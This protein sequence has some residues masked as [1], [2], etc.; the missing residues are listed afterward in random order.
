VKIPTLNC[1]NVTQS[2]CFNNTFRSATKLETIEKIILKEDG[3][4]TFANAFT[5]AKALKNITFEGVIGQNIDFKDCTL[6]THESLM[7][8]I[9][10][11]QRYDGDG[12]THTVTL[13]Q[14]NISKLSEQEIAFVTQKG[15]TIA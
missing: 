11:L 3:T 1:V 14:S 10:A 13:G 15:W 6:L 12:N 7:S 4:Q 8:I 2:G 9:N 5:N